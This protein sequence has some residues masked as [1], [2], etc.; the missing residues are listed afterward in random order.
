MDTLLDITITA[1]FTVG[2]LI[3]RVDLVGGG[4]ERVVLR[5]G[6]FKGPMGDVPLRV[7]L[8]AEPAPGGE[9]PLAPARI[10]QPGAPAGLLVDVKDA[11]G[12][13]GIAIPEGGRVAVQLAWGAS[14]HE[15]VPGTVH[16]GT[17]FGSWEH[18]MC[19][20][21]VGLDA[22]GGAS[23]GDRARFIRALRRLRDKP[24]RERQCA[25]AD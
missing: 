5:D 11:F 24:R 9:A 16:E 21:L 20:R 8:T 19:A 14:C 6:R 2:D 15:E 12:D 25:G 4:A 13:H 1:P 7:T 3:A 10:D 18:I 17:R 22:A 23:T